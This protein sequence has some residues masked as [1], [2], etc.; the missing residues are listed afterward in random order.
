LAYL[1]PVGG[2]GGVPVWDPRCKELGTL[3]IV[4]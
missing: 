2:G 1:G 4:V 3:S